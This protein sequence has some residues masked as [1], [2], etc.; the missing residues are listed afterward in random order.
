MSTVP[1]HRVHRSGTPC[2]PFRHTV[3]TVAEEC[4]GRCLRNGILLHGVNPGA[5]PVKKAYGF[6]R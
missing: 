3:S 1:A 5:D 4:V 2:P 6:G